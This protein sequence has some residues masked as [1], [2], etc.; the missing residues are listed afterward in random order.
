MEMEMAGRKR[1][2]CLG[3]KVDTGKMGEHYMLRDEVWNK[4]HTSAVGMLCVGC[5]EVRLGRQ[6]VPA[7]FHPCYINN[8]NYGFRSSR[9]S[10]RLGFYDGN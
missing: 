7:D 9:L 10:Q 5:V 1:F 8:R 3:C 6:L 4:V 2:I